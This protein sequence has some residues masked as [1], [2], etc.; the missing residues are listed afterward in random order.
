MPQRGGYGNVSSSQYFTP[1]PAD[2][3]S[4]D[5]RGSAPDDPGEHGP[6][7]QPGGGGSEREHE[8][9]EQVEQGGTAPAP[10]HQQHRLDRNGAERGVTAQQTGAEHHGEGGRGD[11]T[12]QPRHQ[13][14]GQRTADVD[15]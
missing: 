12:A 15:E 10:L 14:E 1:I 3:P 11:R 4:A 6:R 13:A 5:R 2:A 8:R 9:A 7:E